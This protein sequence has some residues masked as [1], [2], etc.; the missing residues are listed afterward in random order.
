MPRDAL[1]RTMR[2][3]EYQRAVDR[4]N[5]YVFFFDL[6][7]EDIMIEP[8][9]PVIWSEGWSR[10][11]E[12]IVREGGPSSEARAS[13]PVRSSWS[14]PTSKVWPAFPPVITG[15]FRCDASDEREDAAT[16]NKAVGTRGPG[17]LLF[18]VAAK[19]P[20]AVWDTVHPGISRPGDWTSKPMGHPQGL[21]DGSEPPS[22]PSSKGGAVRSRPSSSRIGLPA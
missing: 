22:L 19:Y 14:I 8:M 21:G 11:L 9:D 3:K 5:S 7:S 10:R 1:S 13:R 6:N 16:G 20:Q 15:G 12:A 2:A 18:R 4:V 17:A